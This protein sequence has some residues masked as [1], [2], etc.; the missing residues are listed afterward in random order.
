MNTS[1]SNRKE[2]SK[3]LAEYA[4]TY[5]VHLEIISVQRN[6]IFD[7]HVA[8]HDLKQNSHMNLVLRI[9]AHDVIDYAIRPKDPNIIEGGAQLKFSTNDPRL[10]DPRLQYVPGGDGELFDPAKRFQLLELDQSY[11]IARRFEVEELHRHV[12]VI[13]G[14]Q[15]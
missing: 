9:F 10:D 14:R 7:I 11:I 3:F 4:T 6:E 5:L 1:N 15:P 2:I 13:P 8:S 12:W